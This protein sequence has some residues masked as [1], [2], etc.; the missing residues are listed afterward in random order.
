MMGVA[1][2]V[3]LTLDKI[4]VNLDFHIFDI[5][6]LDVLLG[7]PLEK[8]LDLSEGSLDEKLREAASA[9]YISFLEN[10]SAKPAPKQ[11][12]LN[13]V[14]HVFP[15]VSSKLARF[16]V[17][18]FSAP[19]VCNLEGTLHFCEDERSS[20]STSFKS[21]PAG[22]FYVD[23]DLD[24]KSTL[25]FHDESLEMNNPWAME[26]YETLTLKSVGKDP[27]DKHGSFILE[28]PQEPCSQDIPP[29][30]A[31]LFATCLCMD[32]NLLSMLSCKMFTRMVVDAFVYRKHCRFRS[33]TVALTMQLEH[34]Q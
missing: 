20:L 7:Y 24:Q 25:I 8:L 28:T 22:P 9:N 15:F 12:L 32:L 19:K 6:D 17:A 27:T 21:L 16:E 31:L 29:E 1:C 18:E 30:S 2:V 11:N 26:F 23:F 34:H 10:H 4:K 13:D 3:L 14:M 5:L 33:C